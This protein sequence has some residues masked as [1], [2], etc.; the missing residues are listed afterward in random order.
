MKTTE[1]CYLINFDSADCYGYFAIDSKNTGRTLYE[2]IIAAIKHE[3]DGSF[4]SF[5]VVDLGPNDDV[6]ER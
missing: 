1:H 5:N 2:E 4:S 3:C 6:V